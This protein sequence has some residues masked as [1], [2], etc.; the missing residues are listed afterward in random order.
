M[1]FISEIIRG[2]ITWLFLN[3]SGLTFLANYVQ[4]A[5]SK[6]VTAK[7]KLE[8]DNKT[9]RYLNSDAFRWRL[10]IKNVVYYKVKW[11]L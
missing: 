11:R 9:M 4:A 1:V 10:H 2:E 7:R 8:G 5:P 3:L 6:Q